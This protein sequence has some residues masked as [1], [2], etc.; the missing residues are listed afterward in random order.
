MHVY[1]RA[2]K[3]TFPVFLFFLAFLYADEADKRIEKLQAD[4]EHSLV[5]PCCWNMTVDIHDSPAS[6]KVRKQITELLSAGKTKE[7]ILEFMS[8]PQQYGE[9]ILA[10]PSSKTF[11][12]KS[13]YWL[14][15]VSFVL[16]LFVV[17]SAIRRLSRSKV[18]K[19]KKS[20]KVSK[21]KNQSGSQWEERVEQE[22]KRLE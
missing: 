6:H 9:R 1:K 12:G 10:I 19:T 18:T 20:S 11:L 2:L 21:T 16:G 3:L 15:P 4:I 14:V 8:S 13:A 5:A 17:G 7:Q 22:L